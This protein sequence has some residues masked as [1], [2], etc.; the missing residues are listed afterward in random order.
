[1][2]MTMTRTPDPATGEDII[3]LTLDGG[4]TITCRRQDAQQL[5]DA[6]AFAVVRW[7]RDV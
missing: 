4:K 6:F 2:Q 3:T 5:L 1:M 7:V